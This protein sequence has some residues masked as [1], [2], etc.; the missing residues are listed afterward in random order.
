MEKLFWKGQH[1][2][3]SPQAKAKCAATSG[4]TEGSSRVVSWLNLTW[5][6]LTV[7][8][9]S[10]RVLIGHRGH[11]RI[12]QLS[13]P[14][15]RSEHNSTWHQSDTHLSFPLKWKSTPEIENPIVC[16]MQSFQDCQRFKYFAIMGQTNNSWT[17]SQALFALFRSTRA[18]MSFKVAPDFKTRAAAASSQLGL[19]SPTITR[20][21]NRAPG[22]LMYSHY[23]RLAHTG[24]HTSGSTAQHF[25]RTARAAERRCY[26]PHKTAKL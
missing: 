12:S 23:P 19:D 2:C 20:P 25:R 1:F 3:V 7:V 5:L 24:R 14:D 18:H 6:V 15:F 22:V 16:I 13:F 8:W 10:V 21:F 26:F 11:L 17:T 9:S 4:D